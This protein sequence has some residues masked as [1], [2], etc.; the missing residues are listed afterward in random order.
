MS[1]FVLTCESTADYPKS[2][3][4][5]RDIPYA[6]FHYELDGR[7]RLDDLYT[8]TTPEAF[9]G[10]LKAGG[11]STTSQP[12]AGE[13]ASLWEP[14]LE[15]G[16]DI[17]HVTLSSGISGAYNSACVAVEQMGAAY[18]ER[19]VRVIDSLT[20][21]AGYG[22]LVDYLADLRDE[23]R[24][25]AEVA[26]W[27]EARKLNLNAWFFVSDLDCLKR[28][29]RVSA[30]SALLATALKICPV[31][32]IDYRGHLIPRQKIRT[33][34]RAI[35]G[36][37]KMFAEHA[38]GGS[39]YAGKCVISQSNCRGYAEEVARLVGEHAPALAGKIAINDIGTVIGSHTGP[40]TVALF[41]MGDKRVD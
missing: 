12:S 37:A 14:Y 21:S 17:L 6:C 4:D 31:M 25:I 27:C 28:G 33:A 1:E 41:F 18:P 16:R 20:A 32:N 13:Y 23:G 10:A 34:K 5:R 9:F 8:S 39:S 35:E 2:F 29:G 19:T 38:E 24:G 36:L 22:M 15:K 11:R 26:D 3:F 30:T 7:A 40:G